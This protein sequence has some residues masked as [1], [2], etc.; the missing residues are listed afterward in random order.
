MSELKDIFK[1]CEWRTA[2]DGSPVNPLQALVMSLCC[3]PKDFA[4]HKFDAYLY[5]II[6]GWDDDVYETLKG[7][8][9]W[10]DNVIIY[11]KRLHQN[12]IHAWNLLTAEGIK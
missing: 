11:Q 3:S 10:S 9:G 4:E 1:D 8:H 12:F 7:Q 5:G 6:V 2:D